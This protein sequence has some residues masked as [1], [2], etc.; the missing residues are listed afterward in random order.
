MN[1]RRILDSLL[2][3][4]L[5][6]LFGCSPSVK[7]IDRTQPN[8]VPKSQFSGIW[9]HRATVI[10]AD[11]EAGETEGITSGTEKIRWEITENNLIA[12]R[13]YEF[14]P[15]AE[16]LNDQGRDFFGSPAASFKILK[17]FDIQ[18]DY[19]LTNGVQDNVIVENDTDRPWY[20]RK[21][22]RV[23]WTQN[24]V[25]G[26]T[27]FWIG[28]Q[29]Y[30][31]GFF[32]GNALSSYYIQ[33]NNQLE[34]DRPIFT[35]D[36]FDVT[37]VYALAP[38]PAYCDLQL[39]YH[40][41]PRC[42]GGN[43]KVRLSFKKIDP[44][45][46]YESL[47]YPDVL[48]LHDD[49]GNAIVLNGDGRAC[50][51]YKDPANC[52][53][54]TYPY[55][56]QF[57]NFRKMRVAFDSERY[58][59]RTGRLYVAGRFDMWKKSF[60]SDG[61]KIAVDQREPKPI[62]YYGN[63]NFPEDLID[64][65]SQTAEFWNKP[66]MDTL[67]YLQPNSSGSCSGDANG[68]PFIGQDGKPDY[69]AIQCKF[70]ANFKMFSFKQN[71]CNIAN[72]TAYAKKNNLSEVVEKAINGSIDRLAR[73]NVEQACAAVQA[74][75]LAAGKTLDPS[76]GRPMAFTWERKGDLRYSFQNYVDPLNTYGPW[77]VA[78]FA[79]DP[80]T[81]EFLSNTA[82][83]FGIAGDSVAQG[84]TDMIQ[85]LNGD[86]A[87]DQLL[88]GDQIRN[89]VISRRS[90]ANHNARSQLRS[91]LMKYESNLI[92]SDGANLFSPE[93]GDADANRF[94]R[95]FG[96]T[97]LERAYL[98]NDELL[99]G[100]AGPTLYQPYGSPQDGGGSPGASAA[101]NFSNLVPGRVTQDALNV[102]SPVAWGMTFDKNP[103]MN[104]VTQFATRA[105][106]MADFFDPNTSGL[107]QF[108]K[109]ESRDKIIQFLRFELYKAVEAHEI[110]HTVGLRHNFQGSYDALNYNKAF[111]YQEN[112]DGTVTQYWNNPP[113]AQN[114]HRGNEFK[115]SSI[116][117]Y[118]FDTPLEGLH[119]IGAYD[120]AAVRFMYGQLV[121]I[122]DPMKVSIP[123]PRKYGSW[124]RRC[125]YQG[126][127][128][129]I[130][131]LS[132]WLGPK[133]LPAIFSQAAN[134]QSDANGNPTV[135][136][137]IMKLCAM[138]GTT[139]QQE[140]KDATQCQADTDCHNG[141]VCADGPENYDIDTSCDTPIDT[142]ARTMV[143]KM[144]ANAQ[145]AGDYSDCYLLASDLNDLLDG[146]SKLLPDA[147]K[148]PAG[149]IQAVK[150]LWEARKV[151]P[152][153]QVI[154]QQVQ[155]LLSPPDFQNP[156]MPLSETKLSKGF[157][158]SKYY[159]QV[160]YMYCSDLFAQFSDP[161]C[162][163]WDSGWDFNEIT[164]NHIMRYE[165]DY[166]FANF[167]RDRGTCRDAQ[168]GSGYGS[169]CL[170]GEFATPR[171]YMARLESRRLWHLVNVY[172]YYL[173]TRRSAIVAPVLTDWA[174]A[175]YKGL[176][177]LESILQTPEPGH[178][179]L[180]RANNRYE[181]DPTGNNSNCPE[182]FDVP[183]GYQ[184]GKFNQS[185]WTNE[186]FYKANRIGHFY[187]KLSAIR[188]L[189]SS[190]GFFL[191]DF[192]DLFDRRA[193]SL[194]YLRVFDDPIIQRFNA[195]ITGDT[196]GY[197]SVVLKDEKGQKYVRYMPFLD[198]ELNGGTCHTSADCQAQFP[199][200]A[201][202]AVPGQSGTCVNGSVRQTLE[203][204]ATIQPATDW[205]LQFLSLAHAISNFSSINDYSPEFYRFT[206]IAV[207]GTPEDVAY[208]S[209]M[210]VVEF[211]DPETRVTYH[212]ADIDS[213]PPPGLVL[214][215]PAYYGDSVHKS[216]G[217][218]RKWGLGAALLKTAN[219]FLTNS[220]T[221][222][223]TACPDETQSSSSCQQFRQARQTLNQ[224]VGYIDI[225][226]R[227]N[228]QAQGLQ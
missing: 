218:F 198:E 52:S 227:F 186:Y 225:V 88:K 57:G 105:W 87:Q 177:L 180:N 74:A 117:D 142:L 184:G 182:A 212:A 11:P 10:S 120:E 26:A 223:R 185:N 207:K 15:F 50:D 113:T 115:Y 162:Q 101:A 149:E 221:P 224:M 166:V 23:D 119:G 188:L 226:R 2:S 215:Y 116:M 161:R 204:Q 96:G 46:D 209:S 98:V 148:N 27:T 59:T 30:P 51:T 108:F 210:A 143:S 4:S 32:S 31:T 159:W 132:F 136:A 45:D 84:E 34:G 64:A 5:A 16:G 145:R 146:V 91:D 90:V 78:Q 121:D 219:D 222:L 44:A 206:Q 127:Y 195:L 24:T 141:R 86:L 7:T 62:V 106:E 73:G 151:I 176:N 69:K 6:A 228:R 53:L 83:Y 131:D 97:D 125:G 214:P 61:S 200:A 163:L 211:T 213:S 92:S 124:A 202:D 93:S 55:D 67:A 65:A 152:V 183:I 205:S 49:A 156:D 1:T 201:C 187:D 81:G 25:G 164:D 63:V 129:S 37:N 139:P 41:I 158:W 66:F 80:E 155:M 126:S 29:N 197:E 118:G 70:G 123:D 168:P 110:G 196:K 72:L 154:D 137:P 60:N 216:H 150:N 171:M 167:R 193:F 133:N 153:K 109:G 56:A 147:G 190:S 220:Y 89:D 75:E 128:G 170:T 21:Y 35:K 40:G 28:W 38:D 102:A 130:S 165:R 43:A 42:G 199:G 3:A 112:P 203:G 13:S 20:E 114:A 58:L 179:C 54:Q 181:L 95:M 19:N 191:R 47:Y 14:V 140:D 111:W 22:I 144:E 189:S 79:Q 217:Q 77:G 76:D 157:P 68:H 39:L 135:C 100:M 71:D 17:H 9:Y 174:N 85:W 172:R 194:G 18:R 33:G 8:A 36:Y 175:A 94:Q 208:P 103:Y 82:N 192:S 178:Y 169:S 107:A 134:L 99:R 160:N 173:Y 12:Y 48:E 122:W 104:L 138:P